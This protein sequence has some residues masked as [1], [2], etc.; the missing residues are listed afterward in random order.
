MANESEKHGA[1]SRPM[2]TTCSPSRSTSSKRSNAS[3]QD[4][5]VKQDAKTFDLIGKLKSTLTHQVDGP[6]RRRSRGWAARSWRPPKQAMSSTPRHVA[7]LYDKIRKDPVSRMLRDDYTALNMSSVSYTHA[8]HDRAGVQGQGGRVDRAQASARADAADHSSQRDHAA[9]RGEGVA[10]TKGR[11]SITT[12]AETAIANTQHAWKPLSGIRRAPRRGARKTLPVVL[13]G[14]RPEIAAGSVPPS[15]RRPR[16]SAARLPC[17]G[18]EPREAF[19]RFV[20]ENLVA[21]N[22]AERA[23]DLVPLSLQRAEEFAVL[24][25]FIAVIVSKDEFRVAAPAFRASR[26]DARH[27]RKS[28]A[29]IAHMASAPA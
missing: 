24:H 16:G 18:F 22:I 2:S 29:R 25:G 27:C 5:H 28:P 12:V 20:G 11:G 3:T 19:E 15:L 17:V 26:A 9:R 14:S 23:R 21:G 10:R 13:A 8:S 7:G 6:G 4:E 1:R